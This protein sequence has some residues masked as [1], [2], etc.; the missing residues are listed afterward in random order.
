M[1]FTMYCFLQNNRLRSFFVRL[2]KR[3]SPKNT[4]DDSDHYD[5]TSV[6]SILDEDNTHDDEKC[7]NEKFETT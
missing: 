7:E 5:A 2:K 4:Y 1:F 6:Y 3:F